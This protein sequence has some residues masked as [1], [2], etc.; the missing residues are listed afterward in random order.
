MSTLSDLKAKEVAKAKE[1]KKETPKT[2]KE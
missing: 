2:T 1:P